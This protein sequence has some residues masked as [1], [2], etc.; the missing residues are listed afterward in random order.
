M[1]GLGAQAKRLAKRLMKD[2]ALGWL[3]PREYRSAAKAGVDPRR[4]VFLETK[5]SVM[6][7]AMKVAYERLLL[8]YDLDVEFVTL[9][10]NAGSVPGYFK[11]CRQA[12]P[13]LARA[14]AIFLSDASDLVSAL[15]IAE[16]TT[17]VQLWHGCGAF[18]KWGMSTADLMFGESREDQLAHPFYENLDLVTVSSPE[19]VWAYEEAMN[20]QGRGVVKPLGV[21]A[22]DVY[23]REGFAQEA[24]RKLESALP[25]IAGR[26]VVLYAPTFR[27][28]IR[29]AKAPSALDY[30]A[31]GSVLNNGCVLLVKHHPYVLHRPAI[32]GDV[33]DCVY[34]ISDNSTLAVQEVLA[35]SDMLLSDYSS[36]MFEYSLFER[37]MAFFAYD[38]EDYA[39]WRGFFYDYEEL[40][41][42]PILKDTVEVAHWIS[43]ARSSFDVE[44]ISAFRRKFM[45]SCDGHSTNRILKAA[46][47]C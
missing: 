9:K 1:L 26:K 15:P 25:G 11:R 41:P 42:G 30:G 28:D 2:V 20:L 19:V 18:K 35:A 13:K 43:G 6:P 21:S 44:R 31:L 8:D 22:T 27:G 45:S 34:D 23:F 3:F 37:P 12:V 16:G 32:P 7:A 4:V 24:R 14:R 33:R 17:V 10:S 40:V 29:S 36:V 5:E 38:L 46:L 47:G 39:D